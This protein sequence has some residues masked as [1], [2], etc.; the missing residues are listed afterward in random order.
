MNAVVAIK[1]INNYK[2]HLEFKDGFECTVDIRPLIGS[3]LTNEL[4]KP[5]LFKKVEIDSGGGLVWPN[6][7]DICP[8]YLRRLAEHAEQTV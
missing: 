3:G 7:F 6:G 2:I 1:K 5:A 8:N 4:L